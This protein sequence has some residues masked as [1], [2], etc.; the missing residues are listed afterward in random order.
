MYMLFH[1]IGVSFCILLLETFLS[2]KNHK[3]TFYF[4]KLILPFFYNQG[5]V[6]TFKLRPL[7]FDQHK[8]E[9]QDTKNKT[10]S[11]CR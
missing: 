1:V 5:S 6:K 9:Q 4:N 10:Y 8:W 11:I 7:L 2:A 3:I